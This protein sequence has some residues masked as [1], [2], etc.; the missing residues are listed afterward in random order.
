MQLNYNNLGKGSVSEDRN[1][2]RLSSLLD[3]AKSAIENV[4]VSLK[5]SITTLASKCLESMPT[6]FS[7][8]T[9]ML[10]Y[11]AVLCLALNV[12]GCNVQF[13][14]NQEDASAEVSDSASDRADISEDDSDSPEVTITDATEED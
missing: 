7:S 9:Q 13:D 5:E 8:R 2:S 3:R 6:S 10:Y 1:Q 14:A 4:G 12:N 11:A